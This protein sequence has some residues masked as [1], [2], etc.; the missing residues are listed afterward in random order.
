MGE[1][2]VAALGGS[3]VGIGVIVGVRVIVIVAVGDN[4]EVIV[5]ALVRAMVVSSVCF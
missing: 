3:W 4:V 5:G 1:I 2:L